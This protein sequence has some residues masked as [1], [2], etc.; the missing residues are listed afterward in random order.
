M[1]KTALT[2]LTLT[3]LAPAGLATAQEYWPTADGLV[4][5][6][7]TAIGNRLDVTFRAGERE[8][9]YCSRDTVWIWEE[10]QVDDEGDI[11]IS[12]RMRYVEGAMDPDYICRFNPAVK[13][14]DLPLVV[15]KTWSTD[16]VPDCFM[17]P[18][19]ISYE[20]MPSQT[21]EVP[22]GRFEVMVVSESI[23]IRDFGGSYY[24]HP[25]IG[26]VILPGGYMLVSVD[27]LVG[28]ER[29]TWGGLKALYR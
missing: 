17:F 25:Q 3:V 2:L 15:G 23:T 11:L 29:S 8:R 13:F 16:T 19:V 20:V 21:V 10:F 24:L 22:L 28:A 6:Y 18:S 14:L 7:E 4:Y 9:R 12:S 5:H 1:R 27:G 26:P